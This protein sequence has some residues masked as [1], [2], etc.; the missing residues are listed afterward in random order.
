MVPKHL[1]GAPLLKRILFKELEPLVMLVNAVFYPVLN[2]DTQLHQVE[3]VCCGWGSTESQTKSWD[4]LRLTNPE[5]V[6]PAFERNANNHRRRCSEC[7]S[8]DQMCKVGRDWQFIL[9]QT[10]LRMAELAADEEHEPPEAVLRRRNQP[11]ADEILVH[12]PPEQEAS[13]AKAEQ[14]SSGQLH[15]HDDLTLTLVWLSRLAG[16]LAFAHG[17]ILFVLAVLDSLNVKLG[18]LAYAEFAEAAMAVEFLVE[19]RADVST[20]IY[21]IILA[22]D[23]LARVLIFSGNYFKGTPIEKED[24]IACALFVAG[25]SFLIAVHGLRHYVLKLTSR[26]K[27]T[28]ASNVRMHSASS[29]DNTND[30]GSQQRLMNA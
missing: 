23:I 26:R 21:P 14:Q 20:L 28:H 4:Y 9:E 17:L 3:L 30:C 16:V 8:P 13:P 24:I 6:L 18:M 5:M 1:S 29:N 19:L 2:Y 11:E 22:L 10:R 7:S 15:D 27:G 25:Y 12:E